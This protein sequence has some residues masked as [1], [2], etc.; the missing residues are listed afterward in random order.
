MSERVKTISPFWLCEFNTHN[1]YT[2][3][4]S[5]IFRCSHCNLG[6]Y[7][8]LVKIFARKKL[9]S[10]AKSSN[11]KMAKLTVTSRTIQIR[12]CKMRKKIL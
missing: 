9:Q 10:N 7:V 12:K 4:Q 1:G 6:V 8:A 2:D 5:F 11:L 3:V